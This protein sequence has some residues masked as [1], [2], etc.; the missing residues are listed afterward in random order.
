MDSCLVIQVAGWDEEALLFATVVVEDTPVRESRQHKRRRLRTPLSTTSTRSSIPSSSSSARILSSTSS[1]S[2]P[3]CRKRA[4]RRKP[5]VSIPPVV[6]RLDD[7]DDDEEQAAGVV[8]FLFSSAVFLWI[9]VFFF[10][11][12]MVL[13]TDRGGETT[14]KETEPVVA[15]DGAKQIDKEGSLSEKAPIKGLPCM[16][17]LREELSCAVRGF[18][19]SDSLTN[20]WSKYILF[21]NHQGG[22]F[23]CRFVW[24]FALSQAL[25]LV[26]T[27]N[28]P[29]GDSDVELNGFVLW[30]DG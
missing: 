8:F 21:C 11:Q 10:P 15:V 26:G 17:R 22:F 28:I 16:D 13:W 19:W 1:W 30:C 9:G 25:L 27:G 29:T 3:L 14:N 23:W 20:T 24:R 12:N 6:L 4:P 2:F 5:A 7:D 18:S